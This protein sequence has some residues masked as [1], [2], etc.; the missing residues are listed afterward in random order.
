MPSEY[1]NADKQTILDLLITWKNEQYP[2]NSLILQNDTFWI[3]CNTRK[4]W[5]TYKAALKE[6][7]VT[8]DEN[9]RV[10][11]GYGYQIDWWQYIGTYSGREWLALVLLE[12]F[13][14]GGD[15]RPAALKKSNY[16]DLCADAYILFGKYERALEYA[17]IDLQEQST[18]INLDSMEPTVGELVKIYTS[19]SAEEKS[20][21]LID[22]KCETR[23]DYEQ[24]EQVIMQC[25]VIVD[26]SNI[27]RNKASKDRPSWKNVRLIDNYLQTIGFAKDKIIF[28]FDAAFAYQVDINDF[29]T[30]LSKDHRLCLAPGHEQADGHI[31]TK[32]IELQKI[33]P[34]SPPFIVSNDRFNDFI[35]FPELEPLIRTRRRGV[36]WTFIQKR[37]EPVIN[38]KF[39]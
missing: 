2:F 10:K 23:L 32:A 20:K 18:Y 12:L 30:Q 29:D 17:Q 36:T 8:I 15:I 9:F 16:F 26:G 11:S 34:N 14:K 27:A 19:S 21:I 7:G 35:Q 31:L 33:E 22:L 25:P 24:K 38:F 39:G 6:A 28:I 3:Y 5:G 37:L 13:K 1:K 4:Y